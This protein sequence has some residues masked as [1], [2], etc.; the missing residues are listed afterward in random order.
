MSFSVRLCFYSKRKRATLLSFAVAAF[1]I[2][3]LG[4]VFIRRGVLLFKS[5]YRSNNVK[6]QIFFTKRKPCTI[7]ERVWI[8]LAM[9][10]VY[11]R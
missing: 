8:K 2:K 3:S 10:S 9:N 6:Y 5:V 4:Y 7:H 1:S 11:L